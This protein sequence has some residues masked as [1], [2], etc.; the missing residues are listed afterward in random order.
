MTTIW[1]SLAFEIFENGLMV[2]VSSLLGSRGWAIILGGLFALVALALLVA[3]WTKWGQQKPLTK[4][5]ALAF[6]AHIWLLMYA[7]GTRI[8]TPGTGGGTAGG[9][10]T[11]S[12]H[13]TI[14]SSAV[15]TPESPLTSSEPATSS[16][17]R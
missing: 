16:E 12:M 8:S 17:A 4:C 6:L 15:N 3:S 10:K 14:Q 5:V 13:V 2:G 9:P 11:P 7:Y 1:N